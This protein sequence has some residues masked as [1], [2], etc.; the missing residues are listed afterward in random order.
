MELAD[1]IRTATLRQRE[2][3]AAECGTTV[4]YLYQLAGEHRR[5][6]TELA[7]KLESATR[8]AVCRCRLRPDL[9]PPDACPKARPGGAWGEALPHGHS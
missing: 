9:F 1:Y 5:P 8:G 3:V 4:A 7:L 2:R 6:G